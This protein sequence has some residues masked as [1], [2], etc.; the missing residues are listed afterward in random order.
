MDISKALGNPQLLVQIEEAREFRLLVE[1]IPNLAWIARHD[2]YIYWFNQRWYQYTGTTAA[3]M[4]GWG[5]Q[6]VH[7]PRTLPEV[8]TRWQASIE[9]GEPFEMTFPLRSANGDFRPFLTRVVPLRDTNGKVLRWFGTNT[10]V[11]TELQSADALRRSEQRFRTATQAIDGVLW[12]NNPSGQMHGEQ[13]GWSGFTGQTS[14]QCQGY[15]WTDAVHPDDAQPTLEAWQEAVRECRLFGFEHRVRRRDGVYRLCSVHALP[16]QNADG[17]IREWVGVH[18]DITEDRRTRQALRDTIS[19]LREQR[20]LLEVA[21]FTNNVGFW[22]YRPSKGDLYLSSGSRR[23]LNLP[24][25]G[26]VTFDEA[27]AAVY[28]DDIPKLH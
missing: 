9:T 14:E 16:I 10:D 3:D 20:E 25:E 11:M 15:G 23:L 4:Q 19:V 2:G 28:P 6:S 18:T 26:E 21:Q 13:P 17:A 24:L 12:T 7:D 1:S 8:V 22:R 5:W 27:T